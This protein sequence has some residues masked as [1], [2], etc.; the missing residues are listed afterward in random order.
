MELEYRKKPWLHMRS[1]IPQPP[2]EQ[3]NETDRSEKP[4]TFGRLRNRDESSL[5]TRF[6]A[7]I[8]APFSSFNAD[9][10]S[11]SS[12]S[13]CRMLLRCIRTASFASMASS[14]VTEPFSLSSSNF[15]YRFSRAT[16]F[17]LSSFFRSSKSL[18][19]YPSS[20]LSTA[21]IPARV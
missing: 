14:S 9:S 10:S 8:W 2:W 6:R 21:R 7:L 3:I 18:V 20:Q 15:L 5:A 19:A 16:F 11:D 4:L 12:F 13:F 1:L 17:D